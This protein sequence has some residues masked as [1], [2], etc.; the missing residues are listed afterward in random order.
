MKKGTHLIKALLFLSLFV[1]MSASSTQASSDPVII[2]ETFT[3]GTNLARKPDIAR[4]PDPIWHYDAQGLSNPD[5]AHPEIENGRLK[6]G[7]NSWHFFDLSDTLS[8][9]KPTKL[10]LSADLTVSTISQNNF[11]AGVG[12]G[13]WS[14]PPAGSAQT[15][16]TGLIIEGEFPT[17][18]G[19]ISFWHN[20]SRTHDNTYTISPFNPAESYNLKYTVDIETGNILSIYLNGEPVRFTKKNST[21][22]SSGTFTHENTRYAGVFGRSQTSTIQFGY[23]DNFVVENAT[24]QTP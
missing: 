18:R 24:T 6:T 12:L 14:A 9:K 8:F 11:G 10:T 7:F 5:A 3:N 22:Y 13:F 1:G 20:G 19:T 21:V 17:G 15:H 2:K 16:F 4:I 23:I